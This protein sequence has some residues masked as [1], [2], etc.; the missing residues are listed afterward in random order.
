MSARDIDLKRIFSRGLDD[1]NKKRAVLLKD[2]RTARLGQVWRKGLIVLA[3]KT[4]GC[5]GYGIERVK[6]KQ[7][8][9]PMVN[10]CCRVPYNAVR[11][12]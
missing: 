5:W 10:Q 8:C 1:P 4:K 9:L 6:W 2:V 7:P 11:I 3:W 12:L